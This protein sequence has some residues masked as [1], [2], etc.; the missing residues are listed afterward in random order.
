MIRSQRYAFLALVAWSTCAFG[1]VVLTQK[2]PTGIY[3]ADETAVW[4][5]TRSPQS[6]STGANYTV[7]KNGASVLKQG[8]IDLSSGSATIEVQLNEPGEVVLEVSPQGPAPASSPTNAP[9]TA[10][11]AGRGRGR[12]GFN[13]LPRDGAIFDAQHLK[14]ALPRPDDFDAWWDKKLTELDAIPANPQL[15]KTDIDVPDIE[16]YKI[17]L[18]NINSTHVRGQLAKPAK[19]GKFPAIL[20]LQYAGVYPL[21]RQWVTDRARGGWLALNVEAHDMPIDDNAAI[22]QMARGPLNNYQA[23][24]NTDREKSY[25]LRMYLGDCRALEYL[26]SRPDWDGKTLVVMG[27]SMG[28]QQSFATVGLVGERL[29]VTAMICHVPS[30]ADVGARQA[31]R[32]MAYP[33]WA[34]RPEVLQTARY[35]DIANFAPRIK[36]AALVSFGLFDGTSPPTGVLSA[37]NLINGPKEFLPLHSDHGGPG[38]QP[39]EVRR[40]EWLAVL[41]KG[42][43]APVRK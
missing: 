21:Q 7:R 14:P 9:T 3:K 26:T 29:K 31:G 11:T 4:T 39:R 34:N 20:Q 19:E 38:Q 12:G 30:G 32:T 15:E 24:G 27:D 5:I 28:G 36:A 6:N 10:P 16:Y 22:Q 25:F 18:D 13:A 41:V 35:F 42:D 37:F 2:N 1:Q 40:Q 17:T 33:N 43:P 8:T 23:I